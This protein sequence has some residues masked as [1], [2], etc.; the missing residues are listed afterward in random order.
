MVHRYNLKCFAIPSDR[1]EAWSGDGK[2]R[3]PATRNVVPMRNN[4][5]SDRLRRKNQAGRKAESRGSFDSTCNPCFTTGRNYVEEHS[6]TDII[7][8]QP[9]DSASHQGDNTYIYQR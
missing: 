3:Y 2:R 8:I 5:I 6:E 7:E 1:K 9:E 4:R